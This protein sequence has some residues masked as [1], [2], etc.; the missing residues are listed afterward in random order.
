VEY[1][2]VKYG[3]AIEH[4]QQ[5]CHLRQQEVLNFAAPSLPLSASSGQDS[6]SISEVKADGM[7]EQT[8]QQL[9]NKLVTMKEKITQLKNLNP[10][11]HNQL[12]TAKINAQL[13]PSS[14]PQ[15]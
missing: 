7:G 13:N 3:L 12:P 8:Q 15:T 1:T 6:V 11:G 10:V 5:Y 4:V 9:E 2:E 14:H